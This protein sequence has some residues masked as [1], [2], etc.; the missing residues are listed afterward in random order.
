LPGNFRPIEATLV[1]VDKDSS[2]IAAAAPT[3]TQLW[4]RRASSAALGFYLLLMFTATHAPKIPKAIEPRFSDKWQHSLA[5]TGLGFLVGAWWAT[6]R[7]FTWR[8][9]VLLWAL[10]LAYGAF[11]EIT[12]PIVGRTA[13]I[14]DWRSDAIG[15]ATGLLLFAIVNYFFR[16]TLTPSEPPPN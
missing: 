16:Q 3:R 14:L 6:R 10:I 15:A 7:P 13:D 11:D 5:Y 4:L 9:P 1:S 12:Q 2:F 8:V